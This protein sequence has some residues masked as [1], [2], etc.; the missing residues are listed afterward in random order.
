MST[1]FP[2][3][4]PIVAVGFSVSFVVSTS[5]IW[6]PWWCANVTSSSASTG[7]TS[8][9]GTLVVFTASAH[10]IAISTSSI[11][12]S[13]PSVDRVTH[14]EGRRSNAGCVRVV[15]RLRIML[16]CGGVNQRRSRMPDA[17]SGMRRLGR[18]VDKEKSKKI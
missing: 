10:S 8:A 9:V 1:S 2:Y 6:T 5:G 11:A 7:V 4:S 18:S 17:E 16:C 3:S 13:T 14:G 12:I 15:V